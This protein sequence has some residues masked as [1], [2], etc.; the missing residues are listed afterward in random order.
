MAAQ[1]SQLHLEGH[2]SW[3]TNQVSSLWQPM[4]MR[5]SPVSCQILNKCNYGFSKSCPF[6][7][8]KIK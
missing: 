8:P 7:I 3:K 2:L 4:G 6:Y 1:Q 5:G